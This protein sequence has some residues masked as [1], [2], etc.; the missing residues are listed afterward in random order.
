M[1]RA[2]LAN[3]SVQWFDFSSRYY[4]FT[5]LLKYC[6]T[7]QGFIF[8]NGRSSS[9]VLNM[10]H[11]LWDNQGV[12]RSTKAKVLL[13]HDRYTDFER[14]L[15]KPYLEA[16]GR[17]SWMVGFR[18]SDAATN[19]EVAVVETV[20]VAVDEETKSKSIEIPDRDEIVKI[21]EE[22]NFEP[23]NL[24][25]KQTV[26]QDQPNEN[27]FM[28]KTI[29]NALDCDKLGHLNNSIYATIAEEVRLLALKNGGYNNVS[30]ELYIKK[31]YLDD[32]YL[33]Y[34]EPSII[35]VSYIGQAHPFDE[36]NVFSWCIESSDNCEFCFDFVI[37]SEV[38]TK[39]SLIVESNYHTQRHTSSL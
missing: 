28:H 36:M 27:V 14:C 21:I 24:G 35:N 10:L 37:D 16:V 34:L 20:M 2:A 39:V 7:A 33:G 11:K 3:F 25:V 17:T 8:E 32:E 29:V 9:N 30:S 38:I 1:S 6:D 23:L 18:I 31:M 4:T 12:M 26:F 5:T 19:A 13:P 15:I 22:N